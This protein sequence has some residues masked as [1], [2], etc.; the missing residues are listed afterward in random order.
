MGGAAGVD[1]GASRGSDD[2]VM[3]DKGSRRGRSKGVIRES[4]LVK[5]HMTIDMYF[6]DD[7]IKT[8]ITL[9]I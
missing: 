9:M 7:K 5:Y 1:K 8:T 4:G 6:I 3:V 2:R